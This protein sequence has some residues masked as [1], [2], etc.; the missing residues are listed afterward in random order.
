MAADGRVSS[1][2]PGPFLFGRGGDFY[3]IQADSKGE[4]IYYIF[5][6]DVEA[7]LD[8]PESCLAADSFADFLEKIHP[9]ADETC[10]QT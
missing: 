3:Y 2:Y 9:A 5:H 4:H 10:A 6:E 1:E 7:Y 8:D